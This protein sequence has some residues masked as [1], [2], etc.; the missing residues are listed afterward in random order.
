MANTQQ[1]FTEEH[2]EAGSAFS[3]RVEGL[4][5]AVQSPYQMIEVYKTT[6]FGWLMAIDGRV[7]L[8]SRD[9]FLY[10]EM[11]AHPVLF[12]H[13]Q[14]HRVCIIGGGDCGTLRE[15]LRHTGVRELVQV[16]VD[17]E[18]TRLAQRYFPELCES[19]ADPRASLLYQDGARWI[20][21]R[22]ADSLDVIIVD[23]TDPVGPAEDLYTLPFLRDCWRALAPG[24]ILVQQSDS[25]LYGMDILR[26]LYRAMEQAGF[27]A[28][29]SLF[30]PQCAYP[31]GWWSATMARKG[32]AFDGFRTA[33]VE[34]RSFP[35][36]YYNAAIH[37]AAL[38]TPEF[39]IT[40]IR[41]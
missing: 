26:G 6:D 33:D 10:H 15:V 35:T 1:W 37:Q 40:E 21:G 27:Q 23:N 11:M 7:M 29:Q 41:A 13:S 12:T 19:N 18:V 28:E 9:N 3:L 34:A 17:E 39:F 16:E 8:T 24:G 36:R 4:R 38:A 31:S 22:E 2:T 25:P 30:F 5:E 14:P 20:Q 32:A